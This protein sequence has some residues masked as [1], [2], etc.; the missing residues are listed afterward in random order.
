[1]TRT[2]WSRWTSCTTTCTT[3][4]GGPPPTRRPASGPLACRATLVIA[5]RS[6]PVTTPAPLPPELQQAIDHALAAVRAAAVQELTRV[7]RSRHAGLALAARLALERL[8]DDDSRTVSGRGRCGAR[9]LGPADPDRTSATKARAV[10]DECRVRAAPPARS[11][12]GTKHPAR[13][14]WRW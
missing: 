14:R 11:V 2:A 9:L 12:A 6:H 10:G 3:R 8:A 7:S 1:M 13:Q 5:R 4:S